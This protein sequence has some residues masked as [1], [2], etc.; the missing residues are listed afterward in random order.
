MQGLIG[1]TVGAIA[2][3]GIGG[4]IVNSGVIPG[5]GLSKTIETTEIDQASIVPSESLETQTPSTLPNPIDQTSRTTLLDQPLNSSPADQKATIGSGSNQSPD[6]ASRAPSANPDANALINTEIKSQTNS[7]NSSDTE[8]GQSAFGT[9]F[10]KQPFPEMPVSPQPGELATGPQPSELRLPSS[11]DTLE[12]PPSQAD[13]SETEET[14]LPLGKPPGKS[15]PP[16]KKEI[17]TKQDELGSLYSSQIASAKNNDQMIHLGKLLLVDSRTAQ[18]YSP[19]HYVMLEQTIEIA[20]RSGDALTA[21]TAIQELNQYFEI[22]YW[23]RATNMME[24]TA[25]NAPRKKVNEFKT[26]LDKLI[27]E[28]IEARKFE[29]GNQLAGLA[30]SLAKRANDD[31]L[32][33]FYQLQKQRI[34]EHVRLIKSNQKAETTLL[35][36]PD[37]PASNLTHGEYLFVVENDIENA[38]TYWANSQDEELTKLA[39]LESQL[40]TDSPNPVK[41][42][43]ELAAAW[44]KMGQNKESFFERKGLERAIELNQLALPYVNGLD[45]RWVESNITRL[46]TLLSE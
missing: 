18:P 27:V 43:T 3:L 21:F 6:H 23:D 17:K 36:E 2:A 7:Q 19:M 38:L 14:A 39:A 26:I 30:I 12:H 25:P 46:E 33:N 45:R 9:S 10:N 29:H 8:F 32:S 31:Q 35:T 4:W 5:V 1:W 15:S 41:P 44:E 37:H 16:S 22:D 40:A 20:S 13:P 11:T 34:I 42:L 28:S 24:S